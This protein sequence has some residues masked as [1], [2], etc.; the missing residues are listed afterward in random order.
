MVKKENKKENKKDTEKEIDIT[1]INPSDQ[2]RQE[3]LSNSHE[4]VSRQVLKRII[5]SG[6][7]EEEPTK[8]EVHPALHMKKKEHHSAHIVT[9]NVPDTIKDLSK[10]S[11]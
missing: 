6:M 10:V 5:K 7:K 3:K 1:N 2:I 8:I 4:A 11:K 9:K